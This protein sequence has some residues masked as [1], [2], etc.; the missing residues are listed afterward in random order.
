MLST[1]KVHH[2]HVVSHAQHVA[3][4]KYPKLAHIGDFILH[5]SA[6]YGQ[7]SCTTA[8]GQRQREGNPF[9]A[10]NQFECIE[11]VC[12]LALLLPF[13]R[14]F[15]CQQAATSAS[16]FLLACSGGPP[17]NAVIFADH[18]ASACSVSNR[19]AAATTTTVILTI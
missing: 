5:L 18:S 9:P 12:S 14:Q 2:L 8:A 1:I 6:I 13:S 11:P 4:C 15:H 3:S 7:N 17:A 16:P 19:A 10:H